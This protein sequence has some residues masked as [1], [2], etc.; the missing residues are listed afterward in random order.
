MTPNYYKTNHMYNPPCS[1]SIYI[2]VMICDIPIYLSAQRRSIK[3][4]YYLKNE[5]CIRV[6]H[7]DL[8]FI[9]D[10][11]GSQHTFQCSFSICNCAASTGD[12]LRPKPRKLKSRYL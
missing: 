3:L 9:M 5:P 4:K 1:C 7:A 11:F 2:I 6:D 8:A 10:F 12:K